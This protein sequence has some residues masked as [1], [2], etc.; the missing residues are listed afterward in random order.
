MNSNGHP[1]RVHGVHLC[2]GQEIAAVHKA[3]ANNLAAVLP[4][5]RPFQADKGIKLVAAVSPHAVNALDPLVKSMDIHIPFPAPGPGQVHHLVT[6]VRQIQAQAHGP[7]QADCLRSTADKPGAA[8]QHRQLLIDCVEKHQLH[9]GH[10]VLQVQLQGTRLL[11][12][13]RIGGWQARQLRFPPLYGV[14]FVYK[15]ADS[16]SVFSSDSI[17]RVPHIPCAKG[18]VFL[19]DVFQ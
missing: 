11:I 3:D 4:C 13:F 9:A 7:F 12:L 8:G 19:L 17:S 1:D 15:A 10:R 14:F 5:I 16:A 18:R 2:L 6:R